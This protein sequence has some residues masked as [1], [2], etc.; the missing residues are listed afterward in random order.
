MQIVKTL[1][2]GQVVIPAPLRK[3]LA[4]EPGDM[5][6]V[7]VAGDHIEL[8]PMPRDPIAAFSGSL[9][10]GESLAKGLAQE[11][12]REVKRDGKR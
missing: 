9:A 1:A 2:K 8:R 4:I 3:Q 7:C 5:L 6:E 10:G 12:V 11:H